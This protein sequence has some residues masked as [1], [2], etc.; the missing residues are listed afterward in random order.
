[1][2]MR[3]I[4]CSCVG[5]WFKPGVLSTVAGVS[6]VPRLFSY[7]PG[8]HPPLPPPPLLP[9][10]PTP[11]GPAPPLPPLPLPPCCHACMRSL[12]SSSNARSL[13][14][15]RVSSDRRLQGKNLHLDRI[16]RQFPRCGLK[17]RQIICERTALSSVRSR[18][19]APSS[20]FASFS[21]AKSATS[22]CACFSFSTLRVYSGRAACCCARVGAVPL[23]ALAISSSVRSFS[24]MRYALSLSH[25]LRCPQ[26]HSSH[27]FA[28]SLSMRAPRTV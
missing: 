19:R 1:M 7:R 26:A 11:L 24:S 4:R 8:H 28:C 2:V 14:T 27:H 6:S 17:S 25:S 23:L 12:L 18:S 10:P 3:H 15:M 13:S 20:P 5:L 9:F 16:K 22:S 21:H